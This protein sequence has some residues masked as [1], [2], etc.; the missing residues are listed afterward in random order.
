MPCG[1][2][3]LL[4]LANHKLPRNPPLTK[5][6][7]QILPR[8][9]LLHLTHE[10]LTLIFFSPSTTMAAAATPPHLVGHHCIVL[11][12]IAAPRTTTSRFAPASQ[13]TQ[14]RPQQQRTPPRI[15]F[16]HALQCRPCHHE[17]ERTMAATALIGKRQ[18]PPSRGMEK[19]V[20][21][22]P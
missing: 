19:S 12:S 3:H 17:R 14:L 10:T 11:A 13:N 6:T 5:L 4:K 18:Q 16:L 15:F 9:H 1:N 2:P 21:V 8:H 20:R 22:K 7:T